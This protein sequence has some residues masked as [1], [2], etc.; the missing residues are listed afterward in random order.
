VQSDG[1]GSTMVPSA[2]LRFGGSGSRFCAGRFTKLAK[3]SGFADRAQE[4]D[5]RADI[6]VAS[7]AVTHSV[8]VQGRF[9]DGGVAEGHPE[10]PGPIFE[11]VP[12]G[13]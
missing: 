3:E 1:S 6:M 9:E 2:G 4:A 7:A 8:T 11:T 13:S 5:A 10:T 12:E